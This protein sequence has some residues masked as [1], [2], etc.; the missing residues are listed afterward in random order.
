MKMPSRRTRLESRPSRYSDTH[1]KDRQLSIVMRLKAKS[2]QRASARKE[3]LIELEER[4][5]CKK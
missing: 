1:R 2:K 4:I 5:V 3:I